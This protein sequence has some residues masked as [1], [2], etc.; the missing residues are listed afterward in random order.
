MGHEISTPYRL[1][2]PDGT[3]AIFNDPTG[4]PELVG[5]LL[6]V[7]GLDSPPVR[8]SADDIPE[9]DG[10]D[11]DTAYYGGRP[12]TLT[13][14]IKAGLATAARNAAIDR[15]LRAG[16]AND[17]D[18]ILRWTETGRA[19]TALWLRQQVEPKITGVEGSPRKNFLLSMFSAHPMVRSWALHTISDAT[20][21]LD[22]A[23]ASIVNAGNRPAYPVLRL[24]GASA[25]GPRIRN[26]TLVADI[27]FKAG[28]TVPAAKWVEID[29]DPTTRSVIDSDGVNQYG[30]VDLANT[31]W[32]YIQPVAGGN[33]WTAT[34]GTRLDVTW[35]DAWRG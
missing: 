34:S 20:G 1:T 30:N 18:A 6:D 16:D 11:V 5:I 2:G 3:I 19:E 9:G 31:Q 23:A 22:I 10:A 14:M 25:A 29:T 12:I 15:L 7:A 24:Y 27:K 33:R 28:Y 32:P 17:S 21:A 8:F 13:G 26:E 35:R 4:P